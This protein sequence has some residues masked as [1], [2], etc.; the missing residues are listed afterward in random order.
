[1]NIFARARPS[2][3]RVGLGLATPLVQ[4]PD[5]EEERREQPSRLPGAHDQ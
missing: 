4:R 2:I 3:A 1:M 5:E